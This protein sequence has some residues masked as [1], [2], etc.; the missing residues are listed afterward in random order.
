MAAL[1]VGYFIVVGNAWPREGVIGMVSALFTRSGPLRSR[2]AGCWDAS[3]LKLLVS[4][5]FYFWSAG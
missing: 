5:H 1:L 2:F 3:S 4:P